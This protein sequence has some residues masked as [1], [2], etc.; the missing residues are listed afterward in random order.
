MV[1]NPSWQLYFDSLRDGV[2]STGLLSK[3]ADVAQGTSNT[4]RDTTGLSLILVA[5]ITCLAMSGISLI[6]VLILRGALLGSVIISILP[7]CMGL[8]VMQGT[9]TK[10]VL[11]G[12]IVYGL[13]SAAVS[14]G[15]VIRKMIHS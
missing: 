4:E 3:R 13:A 1:A 8:A 11:G 12:L 9:K 6:D 15:V 7:C 14:T 10:L 2:L 5:A